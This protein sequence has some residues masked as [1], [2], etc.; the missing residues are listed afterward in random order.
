[1]GLFRNSFSVA[2][3]LLTDEAKLVNLKEALEIHTLNQLHP[4]PTYAEIVATCK[5]YD[6]SM[7]QQRVIQI[8]ARHT[9]FQKGTSVLLPYHYEG[10]RA[11][12]LLSAGSARRSRRKLRKLKRAG[13]SRDFKRSHGESSKKTQSRP[14]NRGGDACYM[15]DSREH[16]AFGDRT[17]TDDSEKMKIS[18]KRVTFY[19]KQ[20]SP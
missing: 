14:S 11:I 16:R 17:D 15:C 18:T 10:Q 6:Q 3:L 1:M 7:E 8:F 19:L 12:L 13:R 2:I 9:Q 4:N 5:R 20:V